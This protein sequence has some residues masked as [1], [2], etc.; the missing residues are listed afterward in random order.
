M[1][2]VNARRPGGDLGVAP[3]QS[4]QCVVQPAF[5]PGAW[6][7]WPTQAMLRVHWEGHGL[8]GPC[9]WGHAKV[10]WGEQWLPGLQGKGLGSQQWLHPSQPMVLGRRPSPGSPPSVILYF[11]D[12]GS[13]T[14][15]WKKHL[16]PLCPLVRATLGV[17]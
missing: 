4:S 13:P 8:P 15:P 5:Q 16:V 1:G 3:G 11:L 9:C 14:W 17:A 10:A 12:L 6:A 7:A 2:S